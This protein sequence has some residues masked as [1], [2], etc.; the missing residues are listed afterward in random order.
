MHD[1]PPHNSTAE[2]GMG[3]QAELARALLIASSLPCFL[4]EE[5]MRHATWIQ[6]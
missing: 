4:W 3:T 5:A 1:S 6:S 2:Q